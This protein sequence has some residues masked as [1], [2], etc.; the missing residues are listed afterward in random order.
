MADHD[1]DEK[2]ADKPI[3][4]FSFEI[5]SNTKVYTAYI[6]LNKKS[7]YIKITVEPNVNSKTYCK[8][9]TLEEINSVAKDYFT[10]FK[11]SISK[12]F[13]YIIRS[14]NSKLINI[15]EC[16]NN[17]LVLNLICLKNNSKHFIPIKLTETNSNNEEEKTDIKKN[18]FENVSIPNNN[19]GDNVFHYSLN[20]KRYKIYL[21]KIHYKYNIKDYTEIIIKLYDDNTNNIE[22][23]IYLNLIDLFQLSE[24]FYELF[25]FSMDDIYDHFLIIL[26]NKNYNIKLLNDK[27]SLFYYVPSLKSNKDDDLFSLIKI[28]FNK[29]VAER[30][31]MIIDE[32]INSYYI[33]MYEKIKKEQSEEIIIKD[34]GKNK[35]D[36]FIIELKDNLGIV[37]STIGN[38]ISLNERINESNKKKKGNNKKKNKN[39][40]NRSHDIRM[41]SRKRNNY[42]PLDL[43]FKPKKY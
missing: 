38:N 43:Y 41:L 37:D 20:K 11:N 1:K 12:L 36:L 23:I 32:R 33:N 7:D 14:F 28:D 13:K 35:K 21:D 2:L 19:P 4:N 29:Y 17:T 16:D 25:I 3:T 30:T 8:Y 40:R 42:F 9:L 26:H 34:E 27:I 18:E 5:I 39:M 10:P 24:K 22:H 31:F 6:R 15:I